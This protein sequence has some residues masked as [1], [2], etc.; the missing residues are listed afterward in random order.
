MFRVDATSFSCR[1]NGNIHARVDATSF[2]CRNNGNIHARK[3]GRVEIE[4]IE[5]MATN[6]ENGRK[7]LRGFSRGPYSCEILFRPDKKCYTK[8]SNNFVVV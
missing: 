3:K 8:G 4:Q 1:N 7:A 2:S 6:G 5:R